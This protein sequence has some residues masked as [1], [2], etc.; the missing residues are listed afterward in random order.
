MH[1]T[2][3]AAVLAVV[4]ALAPAY[5]SAQETPEIETVVGAK[6]LERAAYV[7][8]VLTANPSVE[9][10][11]QSWRVALAR[12]RQAGTFADPMIDVSVAP[13][14]IGSSSARLGYEV[15]INQALPWFGKRALERNAMKAEAA[16]S[17]SDMEMTRR[18]LAMTAL[19]L[20]DQ[21]YVA[22]RSL[23]INTHYVELMRS[24]RDA[25]TAQL[26]AGRGSTQDALQAEAAL[27]QMERDAVVLA[28][29]RDVAVAQLNELL[30]RDPAAPLPPPVAELAGIAPVDT[31]DAKQLEAEALS[32][33]SEISSARLHAQAEAVKADA[34]GREY[35]PTI[36]LS[37]SYS[38]MWDMPEHRWMIGASVNV[39]WPT[40]RRAG[41]IDEARAA[42]AQYESEVARMTA[43]A[44]TEVYVALRKLEESGHVLQLFQTRLLP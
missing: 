13:L 29:E 16:A 26:E 6:I 19:T 28:A 42:R 1:S 23:E 17:E 34:A 43:M 11:R 25:V 40:E 4:L 15:G 33:R 21:Y 14:S 35:Y 18:E 12:A 38:S 22:V 3:Q 39:P 7:R 9:A 24:M 37:T 44:R 41:A 31:P 20:Y 5:A 2:L 10:A 32:K 27:T 8:A 36:T 30:Q